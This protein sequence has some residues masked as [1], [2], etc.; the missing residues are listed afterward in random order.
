LGG[1][2]PKRLGVIAWTTALTYKNSGKDIRRIGRELGVRY[3]LEGSVRREA[4][5]VRITAQLIQVDDQTHLW[6]GAFDRDETDLLDI[7]R[8]V[9]TRI[10]SSLSLELLRSSYS[11]IASQG[12]KPDAYDAHLKGRY[13]VTRNLQRGLQR[14]D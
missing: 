7:Q 14:S 9:A 1:L 10:A 8:E 11:D 13:V 2:Q 3:A 12:P 4:G 6:A 5:R